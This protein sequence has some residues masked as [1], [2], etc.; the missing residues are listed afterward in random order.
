M[1]Q[2]AIV[3]TVLGLSDC[4]ETA[5][6]ALQKARNPFRV[7]VIVCDG[8]DGD[9]AAREDKGREVLQMAGL[10][11]WSANVTWVNTRAHK[12][13]HAALAAVQ[14]MWAPYP[15]AAIVH[16]STLFAEGWDAVMLNQYLALATQHGP[17]VCLSSPGQNK[18]LRF[19]LN[20]DTG[21][22]QTVVGPFLMPVASMHLPTAGWTSRLS[23]A[24]TSVHATVRFD[25]Q[26]RGAPAACDFAYGMR[27]VCANVKLFV[28]AVCPMTHVPKH[29]RQ[30]KQC[31]WTVRRLKQ[32]LGLL[33][34]PSTA[35]EAQEL[36]EPLTAAD[37]QRFATFAHVNVL[38]L[39]IDTLGS[40]GV[41]TSDGPRE[42]YVK[43][44]NQ[45]P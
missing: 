11:I 42:R 44:G 31:P 14:H 4:L 13:S 36:G 39:N 38:T 1:S 43:M 2:A 15:F 26:L 16:G 35:T 9:M 32:K 22:P 37:I 30:S 23:F 3:V 29:C 18:F 8:E 19:V 20:D 41:T 12:C 28:P 25:G 33:L 17:Q 24:P 21:L 7:F 27:L 40:W 6:S 5:L 34:L 10:Y 45:A